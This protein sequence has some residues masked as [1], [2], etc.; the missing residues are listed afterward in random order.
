MEARRVSEECMCMEA[1]RVSEVAVEQ[2]SNLLFAS[3]LYAGSPKRQRGV[4]FNV[5]AALPGATSS[6]PS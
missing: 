6:P 1:R 5:P 3:S 2:V 4:N